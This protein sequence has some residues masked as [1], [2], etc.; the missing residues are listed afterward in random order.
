MVNELRMTGIR[1]DPS[2]ERGAPRPSTRA[3]D[4]GPLTQVL[5]CPLHGQTKGAMTLRDTKNE[6]NQVLVNWMGAVIFIFID[7]NLWPQR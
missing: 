6:V 4:R 1:S 2:R 5:V 7:E 3:R